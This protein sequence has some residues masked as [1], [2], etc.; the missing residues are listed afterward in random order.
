MPLPFAGEAGGAKRRR[1]RG[2]VLGVGTFGP[3]GQADKTLALPD[4]PLTLTLSRGGERGPIRLSPLWERP[5][6]RQASRV[7]GHKVSFLRKQQSRKESTFVGRTR[8]SLPLSYGL[9]KRNQGFLLPT[10]AGKG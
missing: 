9:R 3:H 6:S 8:I 7:R 2:A 1:V 5:A 4:F 10:I